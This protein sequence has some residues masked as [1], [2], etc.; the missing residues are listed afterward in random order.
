MEQK[1]KIVLVD[2]HA[3]VRAG[4]NMLISANALFEVVGEAS[5]GEM[6]M[7]L[8]EDLKPDIVIMDL[9]MP[10][11][12]GL[13]ASQ[14][15]TQRYAEAL[16][17][18]FSVYENQVYIARALSSGAKGYITKN[19]APELLFDA[20]NTVISGGI[21]IEDGLVNNGEEDNRFI[22]YKSIVSELS[23]REFDVFRLLVQGVK[24][25]NIAN[26]LSLA[27][28][29]VANYIT[30]IKKKLQVNTSI[31]LVKIAEVLGVV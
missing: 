2:D 12:G 5:R 27:S 17:I 26:D 29:T 18:V 28:K 13:A 16:I 21:Y 9:S 20:I 31:E 3:I 10:G 15:L 24:I 1:I 11:M 4:F 22:N 14:R 23:D 8:Y 6:V 25:E 7:Q 19:S 30:Q